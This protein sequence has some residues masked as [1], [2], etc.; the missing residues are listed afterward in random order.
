MG[1]SP[2][3]LQEFLEKNTTVVG[4]QCFNNNTGGIIKACAPMHT[5]GHPVQLDEIEKITSKWKPYR[6]IG[7]WYMWQV[8]NNEPPIN[9]K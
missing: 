3:A 9:K 1:L 2:T 7:S 8:A 5:F 6:S 4:Q